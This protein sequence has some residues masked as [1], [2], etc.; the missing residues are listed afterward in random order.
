MIRLRPPRA[1]EAPALS[2]LCMRSKAVWGYDAAFMEMCRAELTL[3]PDELDPQRLAVAEIDGE[4]AGFAQ[5]AISESVN[6][7][8]K[9]Y[10]DPVHHGKGVGRVL[11]Q[12]AMNAARAFGADHMTI[13]ADPG[14][15]EFY[16]RMGARDHG[17]APSGSIPGRMLP[18]LR[19]EL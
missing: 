6:E 11:F 2:D 17:E 14:A 9:L 16:R 3:S 19:I 1:G 5:I 12:W 7:L 13:D 18:R 4:L 8:D 10:V 15:A